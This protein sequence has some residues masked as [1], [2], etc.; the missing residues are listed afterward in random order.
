MT[1]VCL[2]PSQPTLFLCD[3]SFQTTADEVPHSVEVS[4]K[5]EVAAKETA[6]R[7]RSPAR[8]IRNNREHL[9]LRP[10]SQ[11]ETD[12]GLISPRNLN[13]RAGVREVAEHLGLSLHSCPLLHRSSVG[14]I[15][16][17]LS[18]LAA[19]LDK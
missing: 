7:Q 9:S 14:D 1:R 19:S 8:L 10:S 18:G 11:G 5:H 17:E 2:C 12:P 16:L 6:W 4:S 3:L 13:R 15:R